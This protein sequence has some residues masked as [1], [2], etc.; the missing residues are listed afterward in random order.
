MYGQVES[1]RPVRGVAPREASPMASPGHGAA[2][3]AIH[4]CCAAAAA[5]ARQKRLPPCLLQTQQQQQQERDGILQRRRGSGGAY[6]GKQQQQQQQGGKPL[7][8]NEI[9]K[10]ICSINSNEN[11]CQSRIPHTTPPRETGNHAVLGAF[12]Y[13]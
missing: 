2:A 4:V 13:L 10:E 7:R 12:L 11:G 1:C 8:C 6:S 9:D 5:A 3:A